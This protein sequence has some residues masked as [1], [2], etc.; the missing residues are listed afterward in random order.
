MNELRYFCPACGQHF[1]GPE[2]YIGQRMQ[3]P[4]CQTEFTLADSRLRP[5]LRLASSLAI[6]PPGAGAHAAPIAPEAQAQLAAQQATAHAQLSKTAR[7]TQLIGRLIHP[8][9]EPLEGGK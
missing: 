6:A 8:H 7:L 9:R 4:S 5:T 3:C 1:V 2:D